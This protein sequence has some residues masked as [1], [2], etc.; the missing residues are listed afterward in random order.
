MCVRNQP[1]SQPARSPLAAP[2]SPVQAISIELRNQPAFCR[3]ED[4]DLDVEVPS[5]GRVRLDIAHYGVWQ[6]CGKQEGSRRVAE[7]SGG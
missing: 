3:E 4:M 2:R 6:A 1:A 7:G 5:F